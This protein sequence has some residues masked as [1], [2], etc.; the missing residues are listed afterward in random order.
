MCDCPSIVHP[1]GC[2]LPLSQ[3]LCEYRNELLGMRNRLL[4]SHCT[5]FF[6]N[7][8]NCLMIDGRK[9]HCWVSFS[10]PT[11]QKS[12]NKVI[13]LLSLLNTFPKF[14]LY[15]ALEAFSS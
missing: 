15:K 11:L 2:P 3:G 8:P 13:C 12:W 14:I 4:D 5:L 9:E 6:W 7:P 1:A 10:L